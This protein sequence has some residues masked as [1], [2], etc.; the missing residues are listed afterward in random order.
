[1]ASRPT[2]QDAEIVEDDF[3]S[4]DDDPSDSSGYNNEESDLTMAS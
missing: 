2:S 3:V 4:S 1:M